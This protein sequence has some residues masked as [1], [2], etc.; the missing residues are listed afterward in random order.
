[1]FLS[2]SCRS[3]KSDASELPRREEEAAVRQRG[4]SRG[5]KLAIGGADDDT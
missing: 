4:L 5:V 3:L 1:M 2:V